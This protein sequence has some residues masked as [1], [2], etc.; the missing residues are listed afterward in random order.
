M[1][2]QGSEK[3]VVILGAGASA[4]FPVPTSA[5]TF[6]DSQVRENLQSESWLLENLHRVFLGTARSHTRNLS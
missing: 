3:C 1:V 5:T 2:I 4:D 6:H